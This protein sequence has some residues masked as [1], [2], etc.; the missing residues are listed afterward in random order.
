[1]R[2]NLHFEM[3]RMKRKIDD[4]ETANS[5]VPNRLKIITFLSFHLT[6]SVRF[7]ILFIRI[8]IHYFLSKRAQ[9]HILHWETHPHTK[10]F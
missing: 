4:H 2:I 6:I 3:F 8:S 1:M 10:V 7:I 5:S 9:T